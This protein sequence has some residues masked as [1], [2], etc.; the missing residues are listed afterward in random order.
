LDWET[1]PAR[2][3][4]VIAERIGRLPERLQS[5]LAVA[6]VEGETF[7]A[8]VVAQVGT[9]GEREIVRWLSGELDK[10]HRL[11]SA[12]GVLRMDSQHLSLYRF[13]HILFQKYLYGSLD[14][15][16]RAHL[17][18]AVG[19]ALEALHRGETEEIAVQL[20]RHFQEAGGTE[21]AMDYLQQAGARAV[22]MS[23]HEEAIAHFNQALV[24][25]ET[26]PDTP[27]RAQQELGLQVALLVPLQAA[28]GPGAPELGRTCDRAR[29]LCEQ[30]SS[31]GSARGVGETPQVFTVLA[32]L[33]NFYEL[34]GEHQT[35]HEIGK[36]LLS[37]AERAGDPLLLAWAHFML[38][39][40]TTYLGEFARAQAYLEHAITFYDPQLYHPLARSFGPDIGVCSLSFASAVLWL[41]GYPEQGLKRSQEAI[42]LVQELSHPYSLAMA[43]GLVDCFHAFRRDAQSAQKHAEAC[44]R[45]ST[46]HRFPYCLAMGHIWHGWALAEQGQVEEG[47]AEM[48]QGIADYYATG[49]EL[50]Q[51]QHLSLLVEACGK[52][53]QIEEGLALLAEA[54]AATHRNGE[55]WC[56]AKLHQLKGELLR[57]HGKDEA[58]VE[59]CFRQAIEVACQQQAKSWE[60]RAV[61]SLCRLWQ[62][63]G[64]REEARQR[65][66]EVYDWFTEGFDT[67][68]LKEAKA[69]LEELS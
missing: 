39:M 17:H 63:Q 26:T 36:Q 56:E 38:G 41:L 9:V 25:L 45:L 30:A 54:L 69:L 62:E 61:M 2:V 1:L 37:M 19:T 6:S 24:L 20:A 8:E 58:E 16:E 33:V 27:E 55:R 65:L 4:A 51:P 46:E 34:Q 7:T 52:A 50:A 67:P 21:K 3:E 53:G 10:R 47:I 66:A 48:R 22:Q 32:Q 57:M 60:L 49:A 18:Q 15:V 59:A 35:A 31:R 44:I 40:I 5:A 43:H 14:P 23:A 64:K 28:R 11:V 13:R 12:Q 42:T 29:E 68:D